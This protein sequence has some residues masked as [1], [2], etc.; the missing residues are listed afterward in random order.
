MPAGPRM[1]S[2]TSVLVWGEVGTEGMRL[3]AE[4]VTFNPLLINHVI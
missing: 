2:V 1:L 4:I 3:H